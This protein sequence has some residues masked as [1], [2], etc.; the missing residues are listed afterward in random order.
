[1]AIPVCSHQT[2]RSAGKAG[3]SARTIRDLPACLR[4]AL[5]SLTMGMGHLSPK[6]SSSTGRLAVIEGALGAE[7]VGAGG[8]RKVDTEGGEKEDEEEEE[9]GCWRVGILRR[10]GRGF[11]TPDEVAGAREGAGAFLLWIRA[12][13]T[14]ASRWTDS[15]RNSFCSHHARRS[16]SKAGSSAKTSKAVVL[17][18]RMVWLSLRMGIGQ[19]RPS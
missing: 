7:A 5:A 9:E 13:I 18:L 10:V 8:F 17:D 11:W 2:L 19:R 1:M 16:A 14:P 12:R 4:E 6:K 15:T 3:S